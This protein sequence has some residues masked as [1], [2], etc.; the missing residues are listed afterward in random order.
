VIEIPV[1]AAPTDSATERASPAPQVTEPSL[2]PSPTVLPSEPEET[3]ASPPPE[4]AQAEP[5]QQGRLP[6]PWIIATA[7]VAV[8]A[9]VLLT[10]LQARRRHR[11]GEKVP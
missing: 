11:V 6:W 3:T 5:N 2:S 10:W 8:D 7:L 9:V 4:V 1:E